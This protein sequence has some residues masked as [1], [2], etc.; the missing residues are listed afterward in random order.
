M[1]LKRGCYKLT[2]FKAWL[3]SFRYQLDHLRKLLL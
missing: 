2:S 3:L 1:R